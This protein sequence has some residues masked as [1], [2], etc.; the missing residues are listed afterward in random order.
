MKLLCHRGIWRQPQEKNSAAAL[1]AAIHQG[2]G[3]ETD[4]RDMAGR[5]VISHD[6]PKGSSVLSLD[7]LLADVQRTGRRPTLALNIK[8]DGLHQALTQALAEHGIDHHFVFDMAVP[9][10]LGYARRGV[11]FAARLSEL[12]PR[13]PLLDA[14]PWV[15]LDAFESEWYGMDLIQA[16]LA[17]GKQVAVVSPELHGRPHGP[18]WAALQQLSTS[19]GVHLCTDFV[20]QALEVFDVTRD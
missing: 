15:W 12:E 10:A 16:L 4:V 18:L 7:E 11:P 6:M 13:S 9:D 8:A 3:I 2:L 5:L 1:G 19:A 17:E 14:A 20:D